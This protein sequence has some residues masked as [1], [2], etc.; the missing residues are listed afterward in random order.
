LCFIVC[1]ELWGATDEMGELRV[2]ERELIE[3]SYVRV[4]KQRSID[5]GH[6]D[7][8]IFADPFESETGESWMDKA[9]M[10][11]R[12]RTSVVARSRRLE[13]KRSD[14]DLSLVNVERQATIA[15]GELYIECRKS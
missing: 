6:S 3:E 1:F 13:F 14:L 12:R 4:V 8:Q 5:A 10:W 7:V 2:V 11:T 15:S 9:C